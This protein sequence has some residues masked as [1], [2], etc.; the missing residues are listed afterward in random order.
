MTR[1]RA[2]KSTGEIGNEAEANA[3]RLTAAERV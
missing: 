3:P 2:E 1:R